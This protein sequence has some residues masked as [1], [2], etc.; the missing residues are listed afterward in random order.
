VCYERASKKNTWSNEKFLKEARK[1]HNTTYDY[2][3]SEY[4][5]ATTPIVIICLKH[6]EFLQAPKDHINQKQGCP[7][8]RESKGEREISNILNELK[9]TFHRQY[10]FEDCFSKR[11]LPFDFYLPTKNICIEFDGI[12]HF[13]P[14]SKFG[15]LEGF[16]YISHNDA[17]KNKFCKEN[18]IKLLRISYKEKNKIKQIISKLC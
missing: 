16:S 1:T 3:L 10:K 8:C 6:G 9:I 5:N 14:I 18:N 7:S 2:S 13:K 17:I 15:G 4:K 11:P 12:Q